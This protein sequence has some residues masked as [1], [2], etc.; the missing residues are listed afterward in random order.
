MT[1]KLTPLL[2]AS[3]LS[4]LITGHAYAECEVPAAPIIPDG[5]VASE[6]ELVAAQIAVKTFQGKLVD[7]RDCLLKKELA[8]DQQAEDYEAKTA[9]I[10]ALSNA[11]VD[12]EEKIAEEFNQA[13]RSYKER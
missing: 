5:N 11:S 10:L 1:K 12:M 8:A 2:F 4:L 9:E 3:T 6:D 7:Y 13:V